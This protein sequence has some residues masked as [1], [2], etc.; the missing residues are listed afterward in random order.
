MPSDE[1]ADAQ[2]PGR[3]A[4]VPLVVLIVIVVVI[5]LVIGGAVLRQP[6]ASLQQ[7]MSVPA[8]E[9]LIPADRIPLYRVA[10]LNYNEYRAN[11]SRWSFAYFG[12]VFGAAIL[13]AMAG[14]I[15]KLDVLAKRDAFRKDVAAVSAALAAL[16]I[17]L[18]TMGRFEEKW[19]ANRL[20]ASAMENVA[21]DLALSDADVPAIIKQMQEINRT[22]DEAVVA[23]STGGEKPTTPA[24][25]P[26]QKPPDVPPKKETSTTSATTT[27]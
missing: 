3:R 6:Q 10:V 24:P 15:L 16:L 18:S 4:A 1:G 8:L 19:R 12:S 26:G 5:A 9:P 2:V 7:G 21:Y 25:K 13:S 17:T 11:T 23:K 22:R 20:A 27:T 14:V